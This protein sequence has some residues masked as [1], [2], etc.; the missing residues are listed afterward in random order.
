M[1][2]LR[3]SALNISQ[4]NVWEIPIQFCTPFSRIYVNVANILISDVGNKNIGN[5][6]REVCQIDK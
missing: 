5:M 6:P 4:T 1:P 2:V 3:E